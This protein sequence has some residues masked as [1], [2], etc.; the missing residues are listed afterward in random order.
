MPFPES[1]VPTTRTFKAGTWSVESF[2]SMSGSE[3]RILY[4]DKQVGA[5][6][7]LMY[8]NIPDSKA[9]EFFDH[10]AEVKGIF[11]SF[12]FI[13]PQSKAKAGWDALGTPPE[14]K[15]LSPSL[16]DAAV[17]WRYKEPPQMTNVYP[18]YSD[19][20]VTLVGVTRN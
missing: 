14:T 10:F 2:K 17:I 19:V 15:Y 20:T 13:D 5:E 16:T 1:E 8:R 18:G 3:T 7:V 9:K 12:I 4:G 6:L 11:E